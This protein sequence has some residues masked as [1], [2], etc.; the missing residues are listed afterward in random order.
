MKQHLATILIAGSTFLWLGCELDRR[1]H[2]RDGDY[3]SPAAHRGPNTDVA[4]CIR[5]NADAHVHRDVVRRYCKCMDDKMSSHDRRSISQWER[6]HPRATAECER[7][8]GWR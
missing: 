1:G 8:S 4:R 6:S 3:R 2:H 7:V 5:D